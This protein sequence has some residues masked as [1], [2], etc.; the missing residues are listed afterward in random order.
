[1][2]GTIQNIA[3]DYKDN[4]IIVSIKLESSSE[5]ENIE[6]L[7]EDKLDI[8][9][10]KH[11]NKRS[12]DANSYMWQLLQKLADVLETSKD[13][14]YLI[15]LGRYGVFTH[16]IVKENVVERAMQEWK[17]SKNLGQVTVNGQTGIQLQCYFGSSRI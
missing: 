3:K 1:M 15:M 5:L 2:L 8:D 9:I 14:L 6:K 12:L 16:T 7:A 10:K 11:R 4:K 17:L 13:E